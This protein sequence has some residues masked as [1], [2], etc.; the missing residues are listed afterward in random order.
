MRVQGRVDPGRAPQGLDDD[1]AGAGA[2]SRQPLLDEVRVL[3]AW[4]RE[5]QDDSSGILFTSSH[6]GA[7]NRRKITRRAE[8]PTNV[9]E[10]AAR[11]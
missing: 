1:G 3:S 2:A 5:R 6:G 4:F 8:N 7:M 9:M 10:T 11:A